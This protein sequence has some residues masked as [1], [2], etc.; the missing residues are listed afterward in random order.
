VL[1]AVAFC[2]APPLLVPEVAAGAA[3]EL[4]PLRMAC[5]EAVGVVLGEAP[6]EVVV[7]GAGTRTREHPGDAAGSLAGFGV[8]AGVGEG[9]PVLPLALTVGGWLLD[10]S[11]TAVR[12]A[13][14]EVDADATAH[15][16]AQRGS[17]LAARKGRVGLLVMGD[18]S[19]ART[20][21]SPVT[22]DP[23]A[24]AYDAGLAAALAAGSA[25]ELAALDPGQADQLGVS[26]RAAWQS[27]ASAVLAAG[28]GSGL[29]AQLLNA[30]APYGVGYFV[31]T[32]LPVLPPA[33]P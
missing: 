17:L 3:T 5:D 2:P 15:V 7:V 27:A 33:T 24:E 16:T 1:V 12:R 8:T 26:G 6:D 18:G 23:Q 10:R 21:K 11:E 30:Q 19:A 29:A 20:P 31:A 28:W 9:T 22:Y 14:V 4:A 13:Y 32:W 25:R